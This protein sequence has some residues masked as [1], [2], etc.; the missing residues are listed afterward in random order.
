MIVIW[1][2]PPLPEQGVHRPMPRETWM[3]KVTGGNKDGIRETQLV[4]YLCWDCG[5][6]LGYYQR[7]WGAG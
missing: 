1:K 5:H 3:L 4:A 6:I 2:I 7:N